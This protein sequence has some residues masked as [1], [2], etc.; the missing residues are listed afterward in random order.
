MR[1][2]VSSPP[3]SPALLHSPPFLPRFCLPPPRALPQSTRALPRPPRPPVRLH[4]RSP[5][6]SRRPPPAPASYLAAPHAP[7]DLASRR[8]PARAWAPLTTLPQLQTSPSRRHP[9]STRHTLS[10]RWTTQQRSVHVG[11]GAEMPLLYRLLEG[12]HTPSDLMAVALSFAAGD[13]E[14]W[15]LAWDWR[16]ETKASTPNEK[17]SRVHCCSAAL[18]LLS[19]NP[20]VLGSP[21]CALRCRGLHRRARARRAAPKA[22]MTRPNAAARA[23]RWFSQMMPRP[24]PRCLPSCRR[25]PPKWPPRPS[26]PSHPRPHSEHPCLRGVLSQHTFTDCLCCSHLPSPLFSFVFLACVLAALPPLMRASRLGVFALPL[27]S[28][29]SLLRTVE[30]VSAHA[31]AGA[32]FLCVLLTS[33]NHIELALCLLLAETSR[34]KTGCLRP[35]RPSSLGAA[36]CTGT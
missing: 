35:A 34:K 17:H 26:Q 9:C 21:A 23:S 22:A 20:R 3:P 27:Q 29:F 11:D 28:Y 1:D 5:G 33:L 36:S 19:L 4:L 15:G 12:D 25:S 13:T 18:R 10:S 2:A 7:L 31:A 16:E 6:R 32:K 24:P 14:I 8:H 30:C